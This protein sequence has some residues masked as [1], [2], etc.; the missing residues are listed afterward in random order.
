[1]PTTAVAP[2]GPASGRGHVRVEEVMG[3]MVSI[4]VRRARPGADV[5]AAIED[6]LRRLRDVDRRFSTYRADSE[7]RRVERGE[8]LVRDAS[9]D[10]RWVLAQCEALRIRTDGFF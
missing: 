7:V 5:A 10:V 3:T 9:D 1:M 4:D 2:S 8:L 6:V